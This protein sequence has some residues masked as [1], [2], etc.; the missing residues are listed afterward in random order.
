M[1]KSKMMAGGG[2]MPMV[3]QGGKSVPAFV[4]DN[5]RK[6]TGGG[7]MK[8]KMMAGGGMSKMMASGGMAKK[9]A[10]GGFVRQAD[11]VATKG[12]TKATQIKMGSAAI[13]SYEKGGVIKKPDSIEDKIKKYSPNQYE[14]LQE[15][16][17]RTER[18]GNQASKD[19][20][21]KKYGSA[22]ANVGQGLASAADTLL[23]TGPKAAAYALRNRIT[24]GKK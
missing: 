11:G 2:A 16:E 19:F 15:S 12:K 9:M 4:A 17:E 13:K 5:K 18:L 3:K 10:T 21:D 6:I 22:A 7:M 8:S 24:D 23:V 1:M 14:A 20:K